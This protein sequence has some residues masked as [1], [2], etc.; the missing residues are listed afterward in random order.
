MQGTD[1]LGNPS[2][3]VGRGRATGSLA[4]RR[5]SPS[6][7][8]LIAGGARPTA[9]ALRSATTALAASAASRTLSAPAEVQT[10]VVHVRPLVQYAAR[11]LAAVG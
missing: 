9:R 8:G 7:A 1:Q 10:K 4:W 6:A 11:E 2:R 5:V 3:G